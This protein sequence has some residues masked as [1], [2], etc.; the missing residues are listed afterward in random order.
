MSEAFKF[1]LY[2]HLSFLQLDRLLRAEFLHMVG[3]ILVLPNDFLHPDSWNLCICYAI[4][5][6]GI[7]LQVGLRELSR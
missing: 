6:G 1:F 2:P 3:R 7:R 4:W 5:Q